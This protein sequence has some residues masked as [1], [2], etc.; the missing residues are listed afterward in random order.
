MRARAP[1]LRIAFRSGCSQRWGCTEWPGAGA[2]VGRCTPNLPQKT[3]PL[4]ASYLFVRAKHTES[5]RMPR[6]TNHLQRHN[7]RRNPHPRACLSYVCLCPHCCPNCPRRSLSK[8]ATHARGAHTPNVVDTQSNHA[9]HPSRSHDCNYVRRR[10][11]CLTLTPAHAIEPSHTGDHPVA[12]EHAVANKW[13]AC[14][15][16]RVCACVCAELRVTSY[17][18]AYVKRAGMGACAGQTMSPVFTIVCRYAMCGAR[19]RARVR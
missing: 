11:C 7:K 8:P 17:P 2:S 12:E 16:I 13:C 3:H 6:H 10:N 5:S 9:H 19:N 18:C 14:A 15:C 1:V 4:A